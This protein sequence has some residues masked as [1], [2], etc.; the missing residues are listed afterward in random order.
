LIAASTIIPGVS[1][2][3]RLRPASQSLETTSVV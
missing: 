1:R 3:S 2:W